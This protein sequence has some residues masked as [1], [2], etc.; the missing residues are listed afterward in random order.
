MSKTLT[1]RLD[2]FAALRVDQLSDSLEIKTA[3][4]VVQHCFMEYPSLVEE[5]DQLQADLL[6]AEQRIA[7]L[8][9]RIEGA[10]SAAALLLEKVGQD[11][12]LGNG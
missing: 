5:R 3:S 11:D 1:L 6:A 12:L 9:Q 4:K 10:R 7:A 8:E 2:S